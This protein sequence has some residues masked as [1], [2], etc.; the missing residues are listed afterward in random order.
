MHAVAVV[1][2]AVLA[3]GAALTGCS[4]DSLDLEVGDCLDR[5]DLAGDTVSAVTPVDCAEPHAGEVFGS[6]A[7]DDGDFPGVENLQTDAEDG[8]RES[9][10]EFVGIGYDDS[11]YFFSVLTPTEDGWDRADDRTTLCL[12]V[13]DEDVNGSLEGVAR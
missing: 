9:F 13:T 2:A 8:C 4:S 11:E 1:A 10:E 6:V 12:I 3:A 7:H 5:D